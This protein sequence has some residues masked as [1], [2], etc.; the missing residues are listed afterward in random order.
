[1]KS[2]SLVICLLLI[3]ACS[4]EEEPTKPADRY[5]DL[6]LFMRDTIDAMREFNA[7]AGGR[8]TDEE[9]ALACSAMAMALDELGD[10]AH[11][12]VRRYPEVNEAEP[13]TELVAIAAEGQAVGSEFQ[14]HV[15]RLMSVEHQNEDLR[16]AVVLLRAA[17][18]RMP[19]RAGP[20]R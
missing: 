2:A 11:A 5:A 13:P 18:D 4:G 1:M 7:V 8:P 16:A 9:L 20:P 15:V 6:K 19:G 14:G 17:L 3:P 10:R 12:M